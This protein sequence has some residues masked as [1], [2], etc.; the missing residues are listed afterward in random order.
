M[1]ITGKLLRAG[2]RIYEVPISY[3]ARSRE[4]GK[5]VTPAD[6]V[7]A[8]ITLAKLRFSRRISAP[9]AETPPARIELGGRPETAKVK[10][11]EPAEAP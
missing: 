2:H 7:T 4:E 6:G 3:A 11:A 9:V 5:K 8:L 10:P 1:R